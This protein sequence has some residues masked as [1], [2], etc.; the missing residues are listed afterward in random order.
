MDTSQPPSRLNRFLHA[1]SKKTKLPSDTVNFVHVLY[2]LVEIEEEA[3]AYYE[4]L[5]RHTDLPWVRAFAEHLAVVEQKHKDAFLE[6]ARDLEMT[7]GTMA[8]PSELSNEINRLLSVGIV[9]RGDPIRASAIYFS[10]RDAVQFAIVAEGKT[11]R[12][13]ELFR[14][15]VPSGQQDLLNRVLREEHVHKQTLEAL[16]VKH[17]GEKRPPT[18]T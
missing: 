9:P 15:H 2:R 11:I 13:L 1:F 5:A 10:D 16:Y 8:L 18:D 6:K 17:F 12:L 7:N 14:P 4:G 3:Q